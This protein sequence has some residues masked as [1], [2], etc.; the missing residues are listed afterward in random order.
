MSLYNTITRDD[1]DGDTF[2]ITSCCMPLVGF[3]VLEQIR[4]IKHII[5]LKF[6]EVEKIHF[7]SL[8]SCCALEQGMYFPASPLEQEKAGFWFPTVKVHCV[9]SKKVFA[10]KEKV[11]L[12]DSPWSLG[13]VT[14]PS[15][16]SQ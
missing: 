8:D 1:G 13:P 16:F 11:S 3:C 4:T 12:G 15:F 6:L 7:L 2:K 10:E 9:K 5:A 14:N